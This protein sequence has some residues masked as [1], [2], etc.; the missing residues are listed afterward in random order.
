MKSG[1]FLCLRR[2]K[3]TGECRRCQVRRANRAEVVLCRII[4]VA[5]NRRAGPRTACRRAG[6]IAISRRSKFFGPPRGE[7]FKAGSRYIPDPD[8]LAIDT[9]RTLAM[10]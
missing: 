6:T 9:T 2:H 3:T 1:Q 8:K 10:E 5:P 7:P 4:P